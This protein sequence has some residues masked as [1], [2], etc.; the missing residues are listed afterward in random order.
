MPRLEKILLAAVA[1]C[2]TWGF[3]QGAAAAAEPPVE[4]YKPVNDVEKA[5][6]AVL[7]K[8]CARCHQ[9]GRLVGRENPAKKFGDVLQLNV[10]AANPSRIHP[11]VPDGSDLFKVIVNKE[12]P[13][14]VYQEPD[15]TDLKEGPTAE[16][17]AVL[18]SWIEALGKEKL[19]TC[20]AGEPLS[21]KAAIETISADLGKIP[22]HQ[23]KATRY[24]TLDHFASACATPEELDSYRMGVAKLLNSLS[25]H[26]DVVQLE[27]ADKER[28]LIRINLDDLNWTESL[29]EELVRGYPYGVEPTNSL[30][31]QVAGTLGSQIYLIRGDWF[32]FYASRPPLYEKLLGLPPTFAELEKKLNLDTQADIR[33]LRAKR[34]AFKKSGVSQHNR[35]IERHNISTGA[36]WTSY[37]FGGTKARQNLL[38]FPL[39][40]V[41]VFG[42]PV[43]DEF[44]FHHDGGESIFNLPNGFQAYY[45][46]NAKG[47]HLDK[48]PTNIVRDE[49]KSDLAV[50]NGISCMGCHDQG[51]KNATDDV[52]PHV[53]SART[54]TAEARALVEAL[55]PAKAE[56]DSL[57]EADRARFLNA[58]KRAGVEQK[59]DQDP[60]NI[61]SERYER[62]VDA[63]AAA[64]EFGVTK[65]EVL[66]Y[67]RGPSVV[68]SSFSAQLEQGTVQRDAFETEFGGL[69]ENIVDGEFIRPEPVPEPAPVPS[70]AKPAGLLN[71]SLLAG[72]GLAK[73][74]D[75]PK[76]TVRVDRD[77]YLTLVNINEA[78]EGVVLFPN[79]FDQNNLIAKEKSF[80]FPPENAAF[81]FEFRDPGIETVVAICDESGKATTGIVHDFDQSDFTDLGKGKSLSRKI[82][83]VKKEPAANKA[84]DSSAVGRAGIK[85]EVQ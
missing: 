46:N 20:T 62:D 61:L 25:T 47:D 23:R 63:N 75:K 32:A 36:F 10:I 1:A 49:S 31:D 69:V 19:A 58:M 5:A 83:V 15:P 70:H 57:I 41:G 28:R 18:R 42:E 2:F 51:M 84:Q 68:G 65:E 26:S 12:M 3:A 13:Y 78:G 7:E 44:A 55:Y 35:L 39:G 40:P 4:I 72:S 50:T 22:E 16:D 59:V 43:K 76:F 54:M 48:G 77:C 11:G 82:D 64:A 74:G 52:R 80:V 30:H 66:K 38:D 14:D 67:L 17:I 24:I 9:I 53:A 6:Q 27:F 71:V 81:E 8:H 21:V 34:A 79:K 33:N 29:W 56:F 73:V 45:L 60:V 37:D 85:I